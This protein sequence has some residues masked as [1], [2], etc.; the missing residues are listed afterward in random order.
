MVVT[1]PTPRPRSKK[2]ATKKK[3]HGEHAAW[4]DGRHQWDRSQWRAEGGEKKSG[5]APA[6]HVQVGMASRSKDPVAVQE[7]KTLLEKPHT[8][9]FAVSE[10][11]SP[12]VARS[13][14]KYRIGQDPR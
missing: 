1:R 11:R 13:V 10:I 6:A 5:N 7:K 14:S 3:A 9:I 4:I 12:W 8:P 2:K